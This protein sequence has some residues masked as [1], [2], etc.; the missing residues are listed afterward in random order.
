MFFRFIQFKLTLNFQST[1]DICMPTLCHRTRHMVAGQGQRGV[2][3]GKLRWSVA[4]LGDVTVDFVEEQQRVPATFCVVVRWWSK[5][6][7]CRPFYY[8]SVRLLAFLLLWL[9]SC[10]HGRGGF[11]GG[12]CLGGDRVRTK[13]LYGMRLKNQNQ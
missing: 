13:R 10:C 8:T 4:A 3:G 5:V 7:G 11:C 1:Q 6:G 9:G 12:G 2:K